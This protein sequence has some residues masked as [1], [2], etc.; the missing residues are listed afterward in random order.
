MDQILDEG[1]CLF[2]SSKLRK[3]HAKFLG[4]FWGANML[5]DLTIIKIE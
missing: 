3:L 2:Y 5:G 4:N 1:N